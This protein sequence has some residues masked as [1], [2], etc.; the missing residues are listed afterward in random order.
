MYSV[1]TSVVGKA[2]HMWGQAGYE[3]VPVIFFLTLLWNKSC[4]KEYILKN[5]DIKMVYNYYN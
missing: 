2:M 4:P 3:I 1:G 5:I